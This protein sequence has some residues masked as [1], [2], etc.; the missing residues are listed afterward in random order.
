M[1]RRAGRAT[2]RGGMKQWSPG[3]EGGGEIEFVEK[4]P[5]LFDE[6]KVF[7]EPGKYVTIA[8]RHGKAWFVASMSAG[9]AQSWDLRL[10]FLPPAERYR[11]SIYTDTAGSP[12]TSH[13]V[14]TVTAA[15]VIRMD[16]QPNGGHLMI[17]EP[18]P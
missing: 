16:M 11:A 1:E 7:T 12:R 14:R 9:Q 13:V 5:G 18:V 17:L 15:S 2:I 3:G 10:N 4:L 8:R 6:M